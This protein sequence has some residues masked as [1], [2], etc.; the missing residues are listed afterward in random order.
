MGW[1]N[2]VDPWTGAILAAAVIP[3]LILLY[4]LKLRRRS[5][6]IAST[7]LWKKSVE[8]L[9][10]NAPFQKL[11]KSLLLLLQLIALILLILAIMQP[12]LQGGAREGGRIILMIDNSASMSATDDETDRTRLDRAKE[13]ARAVVDK[14]QGAGLFGGT[15]DEVM[16]IGFNEK[17][18]VLCNFTD[19]RPQI[20]NAIDSI[21]PTHAGTRIDEALKLARAHT[22]VTDPENP[23]AEAIGDPGILEIF[24]D[25]RI[26]DWNEQVGKGEELIL[27]SVGN[28]SPDNVAFASVAAE[29]PYDD[30]GSLQVFASLV[31][32]NESEVVCTIQMTID[33][34]APLNGIRDVPIPGAVI[35]AS[36][37]ELRPG[38]QNIVFGPFPQPQ[39]AIIEIAN[40]R[41]D[42][43]PVDNVAWLVT[44]P[45]R[46]LQVG[47]V[48]PSLPMT[49]DAFVGMPLK[50]YDVLSAADVS[51]MVDRN[52]ISPYD[53]LV[54]DDVSP[55]ELPAGRFL[56]LGAELP[57]AAL[58]EGDVIEGMTIADWDRDHSLL[59][60][61]NLDP[62]I[63]Q[64][65]MQ[66]DNI[67]M[68]NT[69]A[70]AA[71]GTV[72]A[73]A[74][75]EYADNTRTIVHVTFKPGDTNWVWYASY[76]VF[77]QNAVEYLST[78]GE[79]S[80][81][82]GL[83]P[84]ELYST[85]LPVGA[86]EITITVPQPDE[87]TEVMQAGIDNPASSTLTWPDTWIRGLYEINWTQGDNPATRRFAVNVLDEQEADI[88][89]IS[90]LSW[91][92]QVVTAEAEAAKMQTPLWPW[93]LGFCLLV[94]MIEW[95]V[96]HRKTYL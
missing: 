47:L 76:V 79:V 39:G 78:V 42:D 9:R 35:D 40:I 60:Y 65:M 28:E 93:A 41:E 24:S 33:G 80:A 95:W 19:A 96:Y 45:P 29:R 16:V 34:N 27:H 32:Y 8:D 64:T 75:V 77:L 22:T 62:L 30:P 15:A 36:T 25:L 57:I 55:D 43:Q 56:S 6:P 11:R 10:A 58:N 18:E 67:S 26:V 51:G 20:M 71:S 2:W 38:R 37:K 70:E 50:K 7:L 21:Q 66:L 17:A 23:T 88:A 46:Q 61:V 12:Q 14:L 63:I 72:V 90:Q 74:I 4:F 73:P 91:G 54:L 84:G 89:P 31:N 83:A 85:R 86:A 92:D 5:K 1:L 81:E 82:Q 44:P 87:E 3:P 94:L 52:S 48:E 69:L 59:R 13:R 68:L 53:L 49:I